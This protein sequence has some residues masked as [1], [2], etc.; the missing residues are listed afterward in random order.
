VAFCPSRRPDLMRDAGLKMYEP[1]PIG[2]L[3]TI[4][5]VAPSEQ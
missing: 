3:Q 2:A 4:E 1:D 5:E